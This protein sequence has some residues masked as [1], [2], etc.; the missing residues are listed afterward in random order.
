[1][2]A[3]AAPSAGWRVRARDRGWLA[4]E[5]IR[6]LGPLAGVTADGLR[7]ALVGLHSVQP[8]TL[9]SGAVADGNLSWGLY[10]RPARLTDPVAVHTALARQLATGSALAMLALRAGHLLVPGAHRA[11]PVPRS[12]PANPRPELTLTHLGRLDGFLDLPWD[13]E[14]AW[15]RHV[16]LPTTSGPESMTVSFSELAGVLQVSASLH[17]SAFD[18]G[19]VRRA[20]ELVCRDPVQLLARAPV[21]GARV[22]AGSDCGR[23]G[24]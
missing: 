5:T 3:Q 23:S 19:L 7:A 1:M 21:G 14:V 4:V 24:R 2:G 22:T 20:L 13:G 18:R 12:M 10:L 17:R 8:D 9:P 6:V 16:S 11:G 15:A